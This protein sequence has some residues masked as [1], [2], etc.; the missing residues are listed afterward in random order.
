MRFTELLKPENLKPTMSAFWAHNKGDIFVKGGIALMVGGAIY[1]CRSM[2]KLEPAL[3]GH[4]T[5]MTAINDN[6]QNG[7]ISQKDASREKTMGYLRTAGDIVKTV[8]PAAAVMSFGAASILKGYGDTKAS[9]VSA[10]GAI[11][12]LTAYIS[13]YQKNVIND[14]GY[15]KH[16]QYR[17][18][19]PI[20]NPVDADGNAIATEAN[21]EKVYAGDNPIMHPFELVF[22]QGNKLW[23]NSMDLNQNILLRK[24]DQLRRWLKD[25]GVIFENEIRDELEFKRRPD[26]WNWCAR[27]DPNRGDEQFDLGI[28]KVG[29][30]IPGD[31]SKGIPGAFLLEMNLEPYDPNWAAQLPNY[32]S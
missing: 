18:F 24:E 11:A 13:Q 28:F 26:G 20:D 5:R 2:F 30:R 27:W 17:G 8:G 12:G 32:E 4:K 25:R 21:G 14:V 31:F 19:T 3:I 22:T 15:E 23:T 7:K 9:L 6:L 1:M 10:N 29:S 16:L